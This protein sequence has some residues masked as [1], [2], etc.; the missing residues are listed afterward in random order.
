MVTGSFALPPHYPEKVE[1]L[2]TRRKILA[3]PR[4]SGMNRFATAL[5]TKMQEN[6]RIGGASAHDGGSA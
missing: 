1:V 4:V 5:S 6:N 3:S 2:Q